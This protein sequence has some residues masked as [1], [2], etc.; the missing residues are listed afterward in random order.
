MA[1]ETPDAPIHKTYKLFIGGAFPRSESGRTLP[2]EGRAAKGRKGCVAQICRGSRK[3]LRNAVDIARGAQPGW[4]KATGLLRGQILYRIAEMLAARSGEFE[5]L[6]CDYRLA[7]PAQAKQEVSLSAQR[8][9]WYAGW[10]DK[11][12]QVSGSVNTVN[13][14]YFD[15]SFPEA[16]GVVA[17]LPPEKPCLLGLVSTLAPVLVPGNSAVVVSSIETGPLVLT[18]A[19]VLATSDVP[20]GVINLITA[21]REEVIPTLASHREINANFLACAGEV[22][23]TEMRTQAADH[24]KRSLDL[25]SHGQAWWKGPEAQDLTWIETFCELK[26]AWHPMGY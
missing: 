21:D 26:T 14:P 25:P 17:I 1:K 7:T 9:L 5:D 23:L 11:L 20:A 13:G 4:H 16:Q 12:S 19:E 10:C 8:L 3:D 24:V 22:D 15:F 18:F 2:I 6:L